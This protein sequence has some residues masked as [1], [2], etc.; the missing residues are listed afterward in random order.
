MKVYLE[1]RDVWVGYFRGDDH[2]YVCP[3][4][5]VVVR[6][7]RKATRNEPTASI[8]PGI[9]GDR[10]VWG[11]CGCAHCVGEVLAAKPFPANLSYPFIV[12]PTC[13]NKRCPKATHHDNACTDSNDV[14]QIGSRYA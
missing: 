13:G 14:G 3:L 8:F 12:C 4:P 10:S 5:C 2:H 6:W 9:E 11:E 1:P 7:R